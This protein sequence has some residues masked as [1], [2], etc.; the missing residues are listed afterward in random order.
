MAIRGIY[1]KAEEE[2]LRAENKRLDTIAGWYKPRTD[3]VATEESIK[4]MG[5]AVDPWNPL[6]HDEVYARGTRWGSIIAFPAYQGAFGEPGISELRASP[7]CGYQY[8]IWAGEDWVFYKPIRPGDRLKIWRRRPQLLDVTRIEGDGPRTFG[9]VEGDMDYINQ[10]DELVSTLKLYVERTFL[11]E[12]RTKPVYSMPEYSYTKEELLYIAK[13][14]QEEEIR[15]ADIRYWED[16]Q[17]GEEMKPIVTGPTTM[18]DNAIVNAVSPSVGSRMDPRA[19]FLSSVGED[20]GKWIVE[21]PDTGRY[22]FT[23]GPTGRHWSDR[24]AQ[25]EGE[26][27]AWLYGVISRFSLLRVITNWMGDD[28]FLRKFIW[29]HMARTR[30]GDTLIGRGKVVGKR[31]E[32]EEY[33][34]DL[35]VWLENLRGNI[36]EAAVATVRLCSKEASYLWK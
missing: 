16:V 36:S 1:S 23:G 17:I 27:C 8:M 3:I 2:M 10:H 15:G 22:Y 20:M 35:K 29:R 26:P 12:P 5:L 19:I 30:V 6:W 9:L 18:A 31:V 7:E 28:G 34:V 33:L 13:L 32:K 11:P 14:M 21:D 25:A 4:K 24:A